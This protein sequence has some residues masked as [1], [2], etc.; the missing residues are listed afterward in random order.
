[1]LPLQLLQL[2]LK[3]A[4]PL[5]AGFVLDHALLLQ[6]FGIFFGVLLR[7]EV[8]VVYVLDEF[9]Q[10]LELGLLV[11]ILLF[12]EMSAQGKFDILDISLHPLALEIGL[13]VD[14]GH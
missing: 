8:V 4:L 13:E 7:L 6:A 9:V 10:L 2:L 12:L 11:G 1:M 5:R 3:L 14:G